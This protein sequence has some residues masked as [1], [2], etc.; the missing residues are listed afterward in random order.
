MKMNRVVA[1]IGFLA[2]VASFFLIAVRET[3]ATAS[4]A[5]FEGYWCAYIALVRPWGHGGME[6]LR[7]NPLSYFSILLSGW[8]NP[9]FL[10]TAVMLWV[11]PHG[12]AG[13]FLRI[14]TIL[15]FPAVWLVF[16]E[17]ELRPR[18]GYWLW[19]AGMLVVLFSTMLARKER[20][21][22]VAAVAA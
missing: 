19:T 14:V 6:I 11:K 5:G 9:V 1:W 4:N 15:L 2:Y 7:D 3:T 12:R 13:A 21:M 22:N 17:I 8:I 18:A 20:D 16:R 10:I